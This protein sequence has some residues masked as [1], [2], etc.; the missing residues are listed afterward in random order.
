MKKKTGPVK[1]A[2]TFLNS[3]KL[4]LLAGSIAI[5]TLFSFSPAMKNSFISWDD[6]VYILENMNLGKPIPEAIT[7]F[8]GLHYFVG[9]YIP[10]TMITY[11]L[12]Y[13]IAGLQPQFYHT[14]NI[15]IHLLNV[16][17]V[18]WFIWL[19]S[20]EKPLV[21]ALVSLFFGIHPMHVESVAWIAELKDMLYSFFFIAGLIAYFK[22]IE[23][24]DGNLNPIPEINL[25]PKE[26]SPINKRGFLLLLPFIFF[27]L[28]SLSKPAAVTFPVVLL[29]LDFYTRRKFDKWVLTEKIPFFI[30]SFII[31]IIAVKSQQADRLLHD[32]YP[33][34]QRLFFASHSFLD[35]LV[36]LLLPL[37]L[38]IFYPYPPLADGHLPLIYYLTPAVVILL[39]YGIY[40]TL[41]YGRLP[42]FGFLFFCVNIILVLQ[43]LSIGDAIKADRYTYISYIGLFFIMAMG[44]DRLYRSR[45][46]QLNAWKPV[47]AAV[48]IILAITCSYLTYA[49][50]E[51]WENDD[52]IATD[53][54]N[55]Y[56][57]DRL[58]LNNKGFLLFMQGKYKESIPFFTK[59]V[60]LKPDYVMAY[61]N[62]VNSYLALNDYDAAV[63]TTDLALEHAPKDYNV[64]NTKGLL[65]F[66]RQ[67]YQE[68]MIFYNAAI[69][70]KKD[71]I[72]GYMYMAR[73][74]NILHDYDN[75]I[76]TLD[77]ALEYA[78]D[79]YIL[80]NNK[81]Y[82]LFIKGR[83]NEALDYYKASLKIKPDY[84][85]ASINLSNC[86]RAMG[87]S[88]KRKN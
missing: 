23:R 21:A 88:S 47:A 5:I 45:K 70:V 17:L 46:Q 68:A 80:L 86:Y 22:Y 57:D 53:L 13:H 56:P 6:N 76:K 67:K 52:T 16:V 12:E 44:I 87:D 65:L 78:P 59:A 43:L 19:L 71:N 72:T 8:F 55:K 81:G 75:W 40:R 79:N 1:P 15:F 38:S 28:S 39:F 83:Y 26:H 36:K 37:N 73:C 30:V 31:G 62:M 14:L 63:K 33:F 25:K 50:C 3:R 84:T 9:N 35:Y 69:E 61:M 66:K 7:Y 18:F 54:L 10:L 85:T 82:A 58:V 49:R 51:V 77:I 29:L 34:S 48:I 60:Q 27:V 32:Y 20:G 74:Y 4:F 64:L 2:K 11:A 42:A 41:K 24:K